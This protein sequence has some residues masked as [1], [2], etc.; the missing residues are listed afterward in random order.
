MGVRCQGKYNTVQLREAT[1]EDLDALSELA[2]GTFFQ[3]YDDLEPE[4]AQPYVQQFFTPH[5][6]RAHVDS[7]ES[8]IFVADDGRLLG[9]IL[10]TVGDSP[11]SFVPGPH[12]ECVRLFID[13][14]VQ[15]KRIGTRLLKKAQSWAANY[16]YSAMWL[17]VWDK[18]TSAIAFY[19]RNSFATLGC[20]P[21]TEGGMNDQVLIMAR[22]L[23]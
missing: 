11:V 8:C 13:R 3:T 22:A 5:A 12:I 15:G 1:A 9:Y 14:S 21:Y 20:V 4:K 16:G 2:M 6:L 10:L 18:N 23:G 19:E 17:K 7:P